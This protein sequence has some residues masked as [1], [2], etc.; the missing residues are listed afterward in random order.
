VHTP[1][2]AVVNL[3]VLGRRAPAWV[4]AAAAVAPDVPAVV[5]H[6]YCRLTHHWPE[7]RDA[8]RMAATFMHAFPVWLL[9]LSVALWRRWTLVAAVAASVL[10]H[11]ALDFPVHHGDALRQL[12]PISDWR[13]ASPISYWDVQYHARWVRL[14]ELAMLVVASALVWRR[15]P[16]HWFRATLAL[17]NVGMAAVLLTGRLFWAL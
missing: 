14:V 9:V 12:W 13:F 11:A 6:V 4:V 7:E 10:L 15:H 17:V 1:T 5:F 8:W 16:S 3:A 2:H